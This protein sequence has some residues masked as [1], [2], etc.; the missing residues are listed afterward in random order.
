MN[1]EHINEIGQKVSLTYIFHAGYGYFPS[2]TVARW[3]GVEKL[4]NWPHKTILDLI[5]IDLISDAATQG[6]EQAQRYLSY[7]TLHGNYSGRQ[8]ILG[9]DA[10]LET[11]EG[12]LTAINLQKAIAPEFIPDFED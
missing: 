7:F 8:T 5:A 4:P 1:E 9:G 10:N 6:N 3:L 2:A 12:M 11:V